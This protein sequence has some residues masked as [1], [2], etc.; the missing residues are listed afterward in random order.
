[1]ILKLNQQ[2]QRYQSIQAEVETYRHKL[3]EAQDE[4]LQQQERLKLYYSDSFLEQ[5]ARSSLGMVKI[6]EVVIS[7]AEISDVREYNENNKDR[8][9]MH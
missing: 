5:L 4:Y 9:I 2:Y 7:P 6:G 1:M 8:D 3:A